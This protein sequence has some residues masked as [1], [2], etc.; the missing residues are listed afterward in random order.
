M[1]SL[2]ASKKIDDGGL[3]TQEAATLF[4][5]DEKPASDKNLR[6]LTN[7]AGISKWPLP[8]PGIMARKMTV[9]WRW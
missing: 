6:R 4:S 3:G 9:R 2:G 8:L 7:L 5:S 1:I